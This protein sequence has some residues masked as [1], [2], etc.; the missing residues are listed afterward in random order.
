MDKKRV[1]ELPQTGH[2][3]TK[4][5]WKRIPASLLSGKMALP[6]VSADITTRNQPYSVFPHPYCPGGTGNS[7]QKCGN[8]D[9]PLFHI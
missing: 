5:A 6:L 3:D 2:Y 1:I 8:G 4:P 9:S 7:S